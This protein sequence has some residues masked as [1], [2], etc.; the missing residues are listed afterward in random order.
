MKSK[1][2]LLA[3][4]MISIALFV[5][6]CGGAAAT[7][8]QEAASTQAPAADSSVIIAEG[9]IEPIRYANI[10]FTASGTISEV[11]V[12]EGQ[13]V[14]QGDPVWAANRIRTMLPRSS[15]WPALRKL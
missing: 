14:K 7:P 10:A 2:T 6:A 12:E 8:T 4:L 9:R 1:T 13:T 3:V 5:S 11:L 15:N